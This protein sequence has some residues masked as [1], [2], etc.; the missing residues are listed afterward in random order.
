VGTQS[1]ATLPAI[2]L[3][4]AAGEWTPV[5]DL[6]NSNRFQTEFVAESDSD[7][8]TYLRFGDGRTGRMPLTGEQFTATYRIGSGTA[9]NIGA[10]VLAHVVT[11]ES[12]IL[13]VR[14][15]LP[16]SGGVEPETL[17]EVR[18][19]APQAFRRQ[20]RAVTEADYAEVAGRHPEVQRAVATRR[21]S[22]SWYTIFLTVD[23]KG[24]LPVDAAFEDDLRTFLERY[25]MA[26]QDVE[27]DGP[28]YVSLDLAFIVCVE[29]GYF[30]ANVKA[31]LLERFSNRV[32]PDRTSGFFHPDSFTFGEPVYLSQIVAKAMAIPGV[33]W[34]DTATGK[35]KPIRFQ[36]WG[37][38]A[39]GELGKG[40][41][42]MGRLEIARCDNDPSRP[43][44]GRLEFS[45]EGGQ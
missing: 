26:G 29:S 42:D 23:R 39:H 43:E 24:G 44:N 36:R 18:Q 25:R 9:G 17:Q 22:G 45:M 14:N 32:L 13:G 3:A 1:L 19:Y 15:P 11:P 38:P 27:I 7:D 20:E 40:Q 4:S 10:D 31:A 34:I 37:E 41:I 12:G 28:R 2:K 33:R 30:V 35:G 21:W 6:L 16:A 5:R 8:E